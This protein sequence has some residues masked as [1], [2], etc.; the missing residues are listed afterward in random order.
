MLFSRLIRRLSDKWYNVQQQ[1]S[2]GVQL[3]QVALFTGGIVLISSIVIV[4]ISIFLYT[5]FY[6]AYMPSMLHTRP[7]H[8]TF[9]SCKNG[10][11]I[12]SFPEARIQLTKK[13]QILMVGQPYKI[14]LYLE[15]P[16]SLVN[17]EL[18][19]FM[20]CAKLLSRDNL[21]VD[22]SCRPTMLHYRSTLL[23]MLKTF[24]FSPALIFGNREE[25]QSIALELFGNFEEDQTRPITSVLI[26]IES[27][28]I[29][30][31]SAAIGIQ[32]HLSG[33]RYLMFHWPILSAIIGSSTNLF[34]I[35]L[36]C[37]LS[38]LHFSHDD[39]L[40]DDHFN[41]EKCE[42][43]DMTNKSHTDFSSASSSIEDASLLDDV[44]K[45]KDEPS[46]LE[47][48][49]IEIVQSRYIQEIEPH[50]RK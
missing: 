38:Y 50:Q 35:T 19:M 7:A 39:D 40:R 26:R 42:L 25:K 20:V 8:F 41:Y 48:N 36:V 45:F 15:M 47:I 33:L 37:V 3:V 24:A 32:A 17:Q 22:R 9:E 16:E 13:Q 1:T 49:P 2:E 27:L 43:E 4:W 21:P 18:G 10:K 12:C 28:H 23:H 46:E 5:A 29:E 34:F 6:Y 30:F 11:G 44:L 14:N 31:Y